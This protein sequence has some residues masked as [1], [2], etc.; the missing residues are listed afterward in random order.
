MPLRTLAPAGTVIRL[1][2]IIPWLLGSGGGNA[3][4]ERLRDLFSEA[5]GTSSVFFFSTG[6]AAMTVAFREMALASPGRDEVIVPGYT[7]YSVAAAA[8]RAGLKVRPVD[9]DPCT[10]DYRADALD[11][12]DTTRTVALVSA[13]L[14]GIP[15][16]LPR[17]EAWASGR[18]IGFFDDAAQAMHARV[19]N[20]FAG[21]FGN[22]GL[23]SFD[24]GKNITSI[25]GGA[26]LCNDEALAERVVQRLAQVPPTPRARVSANVV[27][28]VLYTLMLRPSLY[29]IPDRTLTLG[30]TPF[31][32]DYPTF[33]YS[34]RLAGMVYRQFRRIHEI[35]AER[36]RRAE[37]F[38]AL[39]PPASQLLVPRSADGESVFLR[40][41]VI[42]P[43]A[44]A[45]DLA[46]AE[47]R[48]AGLGA[49]H[50]YPNALIDVEP[51]APHLV[52]GLDDTPD[53]RSVAQRILTFPTHGYV[54]HVD[55]RRAAD[56]LASHAGPLQ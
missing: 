16:A 52:S 56:I 4:Y 30:I 35:T 9:V 55:L 31:E 47:L 19:G 26:L 6:R 51:L 15:N 23:F 46:L 29:W 17:W 8:V 53:A 54:R 42:L 10:L 36:V 39:L 25:E 1:G 20:R 14:Y 5:Y 21:T 2:E 12:V 50:S 43:T 48:K 22:A 24:K 45:R 28:L 44:R 33:Q 40:F 11:R 3:G 32:T 49:T 38:R 7:C 41:P 34:P 18:S 37:S 27:K 13:N